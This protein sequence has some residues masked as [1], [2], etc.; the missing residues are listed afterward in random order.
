MI[1]EVP[2][3]HEF[4]LKQHISKTPAKCMTEKAVAR[5]L[6]ASK[7]PACFRGHP[8]IVQEILDC[9]IVSGRMTDDACAVSIF[10]DRSSVNLSNSRIS[11]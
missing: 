9:I 8:D 7:D 3:L 4:L 6:K 5:F 11:G 2:T 10:L 1:R